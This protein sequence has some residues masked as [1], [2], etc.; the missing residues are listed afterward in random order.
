[1]AVT[2]FDTI[3]PAAAICSRGPA[4]R[5]IRNSAR[6]ASE[7]AKREHEAMREGI[8]AEIALPSGVRGPVGPGLGSGAGAADAGVAPTQESST[9]AVPPWTRAYI[10]FI[11]AKSSGV[12]PWAKASSGRK[13][14]AAAAARRCLRVM[15][16][17]E[18][19]GVGEGGTNV[20]TAPRSYAA[21]SLR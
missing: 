5:G 9:N 3:S 7:S 16:R 21:L 4:V 8:R 1:M 20:R 18:R 14:G 12:R 2:W 15:F 11:S 6:F 17:L 13:T 19:Q 10:A